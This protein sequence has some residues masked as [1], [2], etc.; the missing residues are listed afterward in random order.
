M[1]KKRCR[2]SETC[3]YTMICQ[4][5]RRGRSVNCL[6]HASCKLRYRGAQRKNVKQSDARQSETRRAR[7]RSC[8]QTASVDDNLIVE[9]ASSWQITK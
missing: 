6:S 8:S 1:I 2:D 7:S 5:G 3:E 9:F 4:D